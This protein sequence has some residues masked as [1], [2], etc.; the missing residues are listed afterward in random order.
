MVV[1]Y[2]SY[3]LNVS[4]QIT[5][6]NGIQQFFCFKFNLQVHGYIKFMCLSLIME[7]RRCHKYRDGAA[8]Q[9]C[10]YSTNKSM[11]LFPFTPHHQ[12]TMLRTLPCLKYC[13]NSKF[14]TTKGKV[15]YHITLYL[16]AMR[17]PRGVIAT[18]I[19]RLL[20]QIS[21]TLLH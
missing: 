4:N 13:L 11:T 12:L 7:G 10:N 5:R 19:I 2:V 8:K 9:N 21:L 16:S 1:L 14:S 20:R 15:K 17:R 18:H 6:T 3:K